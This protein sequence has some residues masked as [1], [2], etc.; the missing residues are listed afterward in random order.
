MELDVGG[1]VAKEVGAGEFFDAL[2]ASVDEDGGVAGRKRNGNLDCGVFFVAFAAAE[3]EAAFGDVVALDELFGCGVEA[4]ASGEA[5][6]GADV[7]AAIR[8]SATGECGR[9]SGLW[10]RVSFLNRDRSGGGL[11]RKETGV[12]DFVENSGGCIGGLRSGGWRSER[13]SVRK[14][15]KRKRWG[16]F[17]CRRW[18]LFARGVRNVTVGVLPGSGLAAGV[19]KAQDGLAGEVNV[20]FDFRGLDE[21]ALAAKT[22]LEGNA[23]RE[24]MLL[25]GR[26]KID[27]PE[28]ESGIRESN[29]VDVAA[30]VFAEM[31]DEA[32]FSFATS[33]GKAHGKGF[34]GGEFVAGEDAGAVTAE[35]ESAGLFGEDAAGSVRA[36][37]NDWN[38]LRDAAASAHTIH[39]WPLGGQRRYRME[40]A[41][42][43][44]RVGTGVPNERRAGAQGSTE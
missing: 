31:T 37:E 11:L 10:C 38:F 5:D 33:A 24:E 13:R 40:R 41:K 9:R 28:I 42:A 26:R 8:F 21:A 6:A 16:G 29:A 14:S 18:G 44:G 7:A 25:L 12:D 32:N 30:R 19:A 2:D 39:K 34:V 23:G 4:D 22:A 1:A 36:E 17:A 35:N 43:L 27:L 15:W 3:A 20:G